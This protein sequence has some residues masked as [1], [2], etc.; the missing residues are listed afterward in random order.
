MTSGTF[1]RASSRL[2]V[3]R[4]DER[5]REARVVWEYELGYQASARARGR[6]GEREN[7]RGRFSPL[8]LAARNVRPLSHASARARGGDV[9][10]R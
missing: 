9:F 6:E 5:A 4:V 1:V 10:R 3:L 2:L 8:S 7:A